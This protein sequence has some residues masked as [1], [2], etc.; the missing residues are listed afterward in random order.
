MTRILK[1][2]SFSVAVTLYLLIQVII[3]AMIPTY[4]PTRM[5]FL[6]FLVGLFLIGAFGYLAVRRIMRERYNHDEA[7]KWLALRKRPRVDL[8]RIRTAKRWAI[9][10]PIAIVVIVGSLLPETWAVVSHLSHRNSGR[11]LGYRVSV[12]LDWV[13]L[14]DESDTGNHVWS[15][16]AA[17]HS[18]GVLRGGPAAYWRGNTPIANMAFYGAP[19]GDS[20]ALLSE[21]DKIVSTRTLVLASGTITMTCWEYVSRW[22]RGNQDEGVSIRCATPRTDFFGWFYGARTSVPD[23]YRTLQTVKQTNEVVPKE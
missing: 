10:I 11:L 16:V 23:F 22:S 18:K 2:L 7:E 20:V 5:G 15:F 14:M 3:A 1:R 12:P 21:N 13:I 19:L 4:W 6:L 8:G 17:F 9:W